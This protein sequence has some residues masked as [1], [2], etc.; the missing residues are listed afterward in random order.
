MPRMYLMSIK[1][2]FAYEIFSGSKKYELRRWYGIDIEE[3]STVVVYASGRVQA[4]IGEF[5]VARVV[6]GEPRRVWREITREHDAGV[7]D[8]DWPYISGSKKAMAL[9][10]A[11]PRLYA[12][13]VSLQ[14][15][16]RIIPGWNPPLSFKE[17]RQG[18]P[19][20]ELVIKMAR[21]WRGGGRTG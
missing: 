20:L 15:M 21:T 17:L 6:M 19:T 16:R 2:K 5:R 10:V 11:E 18:D 9:R 1:P 4:I 14:E 13:P 7:D 3:G 8:D 12:R